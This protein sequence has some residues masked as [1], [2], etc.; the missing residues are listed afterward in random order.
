MAGGGLDGAGPRPEGRMISATLNRGRAV[1]VLV[2]LFCAPTLTACRTGSS[3]SSASSAPSASSG[4][5][6]ASTFY[7]SPAGN[8]KAAGTTPATAWRTLG[9]VNSAKLT[10]G[11]RVLFKGGGRFTGQLVFTKT[12]TGD[13]A[14][15][16]EV[17]TYGSGHAT[18]VASGGNGSAIVVYDTAGISL[19]GLTVVG[20]SSPRPKGIGINLFNDLAAGHRLSHIVISDVD[21]SEFVYGIGI[22]S[23]NETSG[24]RDVRVQDSALHGN[25]DDGLVSYANGFSAADPQ[26]ANQDIYISRVHAYGNPGDPEDSSK[27]TGNGIVLGNVQDATIEWSTAN[28][29]GGDGAASQGPV[30]IWAYD[31]TGV[32]IE[33]NLSYANH[34]SNE[35]DGDGFGLDENT[36]DSYLQYNLSYNN[37]GAGY[38]L[39]SAQADSAQKANTVRFNVSSGDGR[40]SSYYGG[41]TLI[42]ELTDIAIYQNTVVMA[43]RTSGTNPALR[44]VGGASAVT[45][46]NNLFVTMRGGPIVAAS[47]ALTTFAARMQGNDYQAATGTWSLTWGSATYASLAAWRTATGQE[48]VGAQPTGL[49]VNPQ[50]KGPLLELTATSPA[51]QDLAAAYAL[52]STSPLLKAGLNL[53]RLFGQTTGTAGFAG[54]SY[55]ATSPNIGAF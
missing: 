13:A 44:L 31:S 9:K 26:Y 45:I 28:D 32:D 7:V 35:S 24:F 19:S 17:G 39:Y 11:D 4:S 8:D 55:S 6:T 16:I 1:A 21:V 47:T 49:T 25:L 30:G 51:A 29:N 50:M 5:S 43:T 2:L 36:S 23:G 48:K 52:R 15:P 12:D 37:S 34:T 10:A 3:A 42:G 40:K 27:N 22:G 20:Q 54:T 14:H 18:I 38:L 46:R 53:N 41:I 33:H